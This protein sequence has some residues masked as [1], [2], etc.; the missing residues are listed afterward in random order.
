MQTTHVNPATESSTALPLK[1]IMVL[2]LTR[3]LPGALCTM[4]L[5]QL[6]A[7][8][9]KVED[10]RTGDPIRA[11]PPLVGS[12]EGALS[13]LLN[14]GKESI[15][16]DLK[17]KEGRL[18]FERLAAKSDVVIDNFRPGV[19]HRLSLD[20]ARLQ[21]INERIVTCSLTGFGDGALRDKVA[22]D[23]NYIALC[24]LLGQCGARGGPPAIPGAQVADAGAAL[25][26]VV[27]ILAAIVRRDATGA[28]GRV[29]VAMF[30]AALCFMAV[31]IAHLLAGDP[32]APC[33]GGRVTGADPAYN[34][35]RAADGKYLALGAI[36]HRFWKA[37]CEGIGRDDLI[38]ARR[39]GRDPESV[40][41]EVQRCLAGRTAA[42][43]CHHFQ[44]KD[45]CLDQVLEVDEVPSLLESIGS[46]ML[47][48]S[49]DPRLGTVRHLSSPVR[50]SGATVNPGGAIASLGQHT[51]L[52]LGEIGYTAQQIAALRSVQAAHS[53]QEL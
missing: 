28:G 35:Y 6:G 21:A 17:T 45:V 12:Q 3:F 48:Q 23:I 9:V 16:L 18:A 37:F 50:V 25:F 22:H 44:G 15:A 36:E 24:G 4:L 42:E 46:T 43:W 2:D 7:R 14:A 30:D 11:V 10:P 19:M 52:V 26:G 31:H 27:G 29:D 41:N 13:V 34:V 49:I 51:D 8:V 5:R 47:V 40:R 38:D 39:S 1:G 20:H 33:G 53:Q 32:V